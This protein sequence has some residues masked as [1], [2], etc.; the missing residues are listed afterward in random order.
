MR[1]VQLMKTAF[2]AN[3]E[4]WGCKHCPKKYNKATEIKYLIMNYIWIRMR[5]YSMFII[6]FF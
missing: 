3:S 6:F 2:K 5:I 1:T 4:R